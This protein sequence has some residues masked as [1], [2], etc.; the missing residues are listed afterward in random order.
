M[1]EDSD[2]LVCHQKQP[3]AAD[4]GVKNGNPEGTEPYVESFPVQHRHTQPAG[5]KQ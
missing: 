5:D 1:K 2:E 4:T 3:G